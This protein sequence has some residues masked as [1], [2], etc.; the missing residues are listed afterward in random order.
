[1]TTNLF[2]AL[3]LGQ[4]LSDEDLKDIPQPRFE[5]HWHVMYKHVELGGF[6]G[7][8]IIGPL[9]GA[10]RGRSPSAILQAA[11]TGGK[12]GVLT[13]TP[14]WPVMTE[15]VLKN[16]TPD[17]VYDRAYRIRNNKGQLRVDRYADLFAIGG[18]GLAVALKGSI[19]TGLIA[20]MNVGIVAAAVQNVQDKKQT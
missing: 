15:M 14:L 13:M 10:I 17:A 9:I 11:R 19:W 5:V 12:W 16:A 4:D 7:M 18:L 6:A 20:G 3:Y 8:C 2:R 1:M